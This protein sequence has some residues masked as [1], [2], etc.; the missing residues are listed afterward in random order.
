[1]RRREFG[2][3]VLA[4]WA[5]AAVAQTG[6]ELQGSGLV[7]TLESPALITD[8]TRFPQQFQ[9][10]P[11]LAEQVRAG[12]LPPVAQRL[13]QDLMV[14][15]PLRGVGKYGG[16]WRRGFI[17]PGDSENGNRLMSADKPLFFDETGTKILPCLARGFEVSE[18]GRRTTLHLRRGLRWS[19]GTP[20]TAD[21]WIFWFEEIYTNKDLVPAPAAELTLKGKPAR[22]VKLDEY[23]IAFEFDDPYFLF[24]YLLAGDTLIGGGHTRQQIEGRAYGIY[25]PKHY[26]QRFLPSHTPVDALTAEARAAGFS[27]WAQL[28]LFKCDWR[29]NRELPTLAAWRMVQPINTQQWV[30]E[31]NPYYYAVDSAGN[32]LPYIDRIQMGLAENPEV[33][34][35]RAIA[36]EYDYQERFIDLG[37]LPLLVENQQRSKYK[38]HLD[39][40]FNGADSVLFP[41]P[42]YTDDREI[43]ALLG[44]ANFRRALSLGIDREQLNEAFWLGLG[45]P[46]S[47]VPAEILPESPGKEWRTRWSM[48]DPAHANRLLDGVGLTRKD[49][50]GYRLRRDN[51]QRL[52]LEITVAQTLSPTWP[53][54]SE[55][56][57][58]HWRQIGIAADVKVQERSLALTRGRSDQIQIIIW[59]NNGTESLYLYPRYAL[60]VDPTAGVMGNAYALWFAS[61]GARGTEPPEPEMRR[62]HALLRDAAGQREAE[63]HRTA[64]EIWKLAVEQ[65]WGIGLVGLSPA[66]MGVRVV[67]DRLE[68]VPG[69]TGISQHIRTPWG[70]HPEQWYFR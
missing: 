4:G 64:Q 43:A 3:A 57:V 67:S 20:C 46:G 48:H 61:N 65:Q 19:D 9:E 18:D 30:L 27:T 58:Q 62:A 2:I 51:S 33:V 40:G 17:G 12:R 6:G 7:G 35:L 50:E 10:A 60:P 37:K 21:D 68:N 5:G 24:P 63:R 31:R 49:R 22:L 23:S 41:N 55:M 69:R 13:P 53:Q 54:Q 1:M 66:F 32:Q 70:A 38:L 39:L 42:C 52:R 29:L 16:T 14:I 25:A 47:V 26:L 28:F 11:M 44:Q 34:N 59:T 36:G 15:Q 8:P 45:T 56:I